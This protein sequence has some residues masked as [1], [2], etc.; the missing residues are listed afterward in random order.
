[1]I[2]PIALTLT[3]LLAAGSFGCDKAGAAER[4]REEQANQQVAQAKN[5]ATQRTQGAQAAADKDI[6][7]ARADF[8]KS[9]E[10]YRHA[11]AADLT[12]LDKKIGD[13]EAKEKLAKDNKTKAQLQADLSV[14][15]AKREAFVRDMETLDNATAAAWDEQKAKAA[16]EWDALKSAVDKAQ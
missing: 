12:D 2:R 8:E 6:A 9:R 3:G 16:R 4:Q 5:E 14:I 13:L 7:A 1:M 11:R 15:R 10:D